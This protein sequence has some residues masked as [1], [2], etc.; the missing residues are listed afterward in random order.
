MKNRFLFRH[1]YATAIVISFSLHSSLGSP[2]SYAYNKN[3]T[4]DWMVF[5]VC[6]YEC[7]RVILYVN[8][9][10]NS[11]V[12]ATKIGFYFYW[13]LV[14]LSNKKNATLLDTFYWKKSTF[15]KS[16]AFN[17]YRNNNNENTASHFE[18][19][20]IRCNYALPWSNTRIHKF[21][22]SFHNAI[23]THS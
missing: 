23:R 8:V 18:S 19:V 9:I 12:H 3:E 16:P 6:A 22:F 4:N 13:N 20:K 5:A 2:Q 7:V 1:F 15:F 11:A 10:Q 14:L 21:G 17:S